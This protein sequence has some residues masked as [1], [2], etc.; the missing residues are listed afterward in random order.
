MIKKILIIDDS[1]LMRSVLSGIIE[2]DERL[3]VADCCESGFEA[4]KLLEDNHYDCIVLDS[5][6]PKMRGSEFLDRILKM[7]IKSAVVVLGNISGEDNDEVKKCLELGAKNVIKVPVSFNEMKHKSFKNHVFATVF[8]AI[9]SN[10]TSNVHNSSKKKEVSTEKTDLK[11]ELEKTKRIISSSKDFVKKKIVA[12]ACSTGGPK[13]LQSV[14]P[15]IDRDIDAPI[16]L[17]QHM[18]KAFTGALAERLDSL[19]EVRVKEAEDGEVLKKGEVYIAQ[20]GMH[21]A[22]ENMAHG[23]HCIKFIDTP[24]IGGLKPCADIMY[25]SLIK[26]NYERIICVVMTGMGSD[27]TIGIRNLKANKK[28]HVIGQDEKSSIVY[29]MPKAVYE[30]GLV[31]EVVTLND[32]AKA[33]N[34]ITGV[35]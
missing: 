17:V 19:S 32:I 10:I 20:G 14:I 35:Q 8:S 13:A 24:A 30:A 11:S 3:E 21:M 7:N 34:K 4:I 9:E 27:G 5:L 31:D 18:P 2:S 22:V 16:L 25:D 15:Y 28:I 29:G 12:I 33:I 26:S 1:A 6:M 23:G